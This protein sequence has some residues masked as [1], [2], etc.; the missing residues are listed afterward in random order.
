MKHLRGTRRGYG[1]VLLLIA[2]FSLFAGC[3]G[4]AEAEKCSEPSGP[5]HTAAAAQPPEEQAP[6]IIYRT[7]QRTEPSGR[8]RWDVRK[9]QQNG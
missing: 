1:V 2:F 7:R 8:E 3:V 9:R 4:V 6:Q 5:S